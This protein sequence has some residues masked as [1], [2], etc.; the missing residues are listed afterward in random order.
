VSSATAATDFF[1]AAALIDN[2]GLSAPPTLA[3]Y[4]TVTHSSAGPSTAWATDSPGGGGDFFATGSPDP[5]LTFALDDTY[6]L[7][8]LVV[9]GYH[10]TSPNNAE[11]KDISVEFSMDGGLTWTPSL[12]VT[13]Q[14]TANAV[15]TLPFDSP[16]ESNVVRLTITDNHFGS[17]GAGGGDRVGLGEIKFIG[18]LL[19]AP[20]PVIQVPPVLDFGILPAGS[21]TTS[22]PLFISNA[23]S[24]RPLQ[25]TAA[26]P[27][28]P[29]GLTTSSLSVP[30]GQ[31]RP[32]HVTFDPRGISGCHLETLQLATN[33]P[34]RPHLEVHLLGAFDCVLD[35]P[36]QPRLSP[37][38]GTF[39]APFEVTMTTI[40]A[41]AILLYTTDGSVP[42]PDHGSLYS[43]PI[44]VSTTT[45]I[46]T[47]SLR[48]GLKSKP[49]T[50]SYIRLAEDLVNHT[51]PLPIAIIENFGRGTIPNKGWNFGHQSGLGLQQVAFQPA[52]LHLI[53][54]NSAT[55]R[56]STT[57]PPDLTE[58]IGIRVRGAFSSTWNPKPYNLETW[59]EFDADKTTTPLDLPGESD[60]ILYYP[61]PQFDQ[62]L[63][64][65]TFTW[66]LSSQTG[67]YGTRFRFVDLF[68]NEDGGDLTLADRIGVYAFAEKVKR[69]DDRIEFEPLSEEGTTGGWLLS[70]NRMDPEPV[71]GFPAENGATSPQFF[72]TAGPNHLPETPPNIAGQGDD[73]PRQWNAFINFEHPN[74]YRINPAQ[75]A[76]IENWFTQFEDVFY[77]DDRWLDPV[78]GYRRHLNTRDFI[79]YFHIHNLAKQGDSLLLSVFPWVSSG[80]R[81]LH[82]GPHWDYNLGAYSGDP[83]SETFY[84]NDRLWYPRLLQD[85]GYLREHIDRWYE[86][87]RGPLSTANMHALVDAQAAE[88]THELASA[89]GLPPSI[90]EARLQSMKSYLADR[91]GWLDNQF[92]KPPTFSHPGGVVS[93]Q[94][95]L[96]IT[97]ATGR[98]GTIYFTVD[99]SDP[100]DGGGT[101]YSGPI[102]FNAT[103]R[104]MARLRD[105]NG[106]WSALNEASYVTGLPAGP[107]DL[108]IS[109]IMYHPLGDPSAEFLEVLNIHP[110]E[111]VDLALVR[112][113]AGVEFTFP[114]GTTLAPGGR[115][116]VVRDTTAF[117]A[118]HG[119]GHP[120]AGEFQLSSALD[121]DGDRI[122][123]NAASGS[124]ILNFS[125]GDDRPWP[126]SADGGGDSLVLLDPFSNPE[127]GSSASWRSSVAPG[128]NPGID[129]LLVFSGDPQADRDH[130]SALLEHA[131]GTS[132]FFPDSLPGVLN[133]SHDPVT[134]TELRVSRS[135][136]AT[137]VLLIVEWSDGLLGWLPVPE[138]PVFDVHLPGGRARFLR[139]LAAP[140][141]AGRF[142]RLRAVVP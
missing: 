63:L 5:V 48:A 99:G 60:W 105:L 21:A 59:D 107:G 88:I 57:G 12:T 136:A 27:S 62:T 28:L 50:A 38:E 109:E 140:Q 58:R 120:I 14:R 92:F 111:S 69:D 100:I 40:E 138:P 77:D 123:L 84:R 70:V 56:A 112:F 126:E 9:W 6:W 23:G 26:V 36:S 3:N 91:A 87:R 30:P 54:R 102:T 29:F 104:I 103:A 78:E 119:P 17:P 125:Y 71:H 42:G 55:G 11:A 124:T 15:D 22:L 93:A 129:D 106:E 33:D 134:G 8:A 115:I 97:N 66:A 24:G 67:R 116:L 74:G 90:W 61:H 7:T 81:K 101:A 82:M 72:H 2:S 95:S 128:G 10:F 121:N 39:A 117:E 64:Y 46:R 127:P 1:R 137:D 86:L 83:T 43:G 19:A 122:V 25:V 76:T 96:T 113:A 47:I 79:D 118:V 141:P 32:L 89:Q 20:D 41:D 35:P 73:L 37:A 130:L 85:P 68:I 135:L 94:F 4:T 44:P 45:Q 34:Q 139:H 75:R 132:D 52:C 108:V 16:H 65:N 49:Q 133:W 114:V 18:N 98:S 131:L 51:S 53:G 31:S 142:F 110:T 13:H 80:S